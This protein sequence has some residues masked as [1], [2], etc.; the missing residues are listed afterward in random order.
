MERICPVA[1]LGADCTICYSIYRYTSW[2]DVGEEPHQRHHRS[3]SWCSKRSTV[4]RLKPLVAVA[5]ELKTETVNNAPV[6]IKPTV[7]PQTSSQ[8]IYSEVGTEAEAK[9]FI[10]QKES[11]NRTDAINPSSGACGLGQALPCSKMPCTLQDYA[12]QDQFFTQYMTNRY[13]TWSAAKQFWQAK[14]W[15]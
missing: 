11:G 1:A 4:K 7:E 9:A 6:T 14:H 3:K 12:C 8:P 13:G 2:T 15:W 10:Y 5:S